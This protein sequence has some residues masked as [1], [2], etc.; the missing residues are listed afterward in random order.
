MPLEVVQVYT[1][2]VCSLLTLKALGPDN[3]YIAL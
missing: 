3:G 1:Y 2:S